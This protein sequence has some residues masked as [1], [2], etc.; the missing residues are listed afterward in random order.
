[1]GQVLFSI[2]DSRSHSDTPH[3]VGDLWTSDQPHAET[4][5]KTTLATDTHTTGVTR[6]RSSSKLAAA[7]PRLR[8]RDHWYR[9]IKYEERL[10]VKN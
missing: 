5:N 9:L 8:R 6:T 10:N 7:N 1:M 2:E 4:F 3:S